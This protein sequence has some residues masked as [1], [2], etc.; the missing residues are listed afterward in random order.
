[1]L[2]WAFFGSLERFTGILIEHHAGH[3]PLWLAPVQIVVG[4]VTGA[5]D[6][7]AQEV[8]QNLKQAGLRVETDL[9]NEKIGYKVREHALKKIPVQIAVGAREA[10]DRTVS[11]RRHGQKQTQTLQLEEAVAELVEG[12]KSPPQS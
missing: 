7:Y 2:H 12:A 8:A 11:V 9:R 1:M 10:E 6:A 5:A 3:L 4:T